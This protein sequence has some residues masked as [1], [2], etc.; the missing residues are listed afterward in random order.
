MIPDSFSASYT[1]MT[2]GNYGQWFVFTQ[3]SDL[4]NWQGPKTE[5]RA[6]HSELRVISI[7]SLHLL[8]KK[9]MQKRLLIAFL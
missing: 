8:H 6:S 9:T 1:R 3:R 2:L 5:L 4:P 7:L